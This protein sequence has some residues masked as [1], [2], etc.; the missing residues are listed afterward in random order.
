MIEQKPKLLILED[1]FDNQ[2]LL[3]YFLK[4]YLQVHVCSSAEQGY[5]LL[6]K[7]KFDVIVVDISIDGKRNGLEFT[8]ELKTN[9]NF[10]DIPILCLTAHAYTKDR[11]NA[12]EAGCDA[13]FSKPTDLKKL[14]NSLL[15]MS[16]AR[17]NYPI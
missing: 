15:A 11:I 7:E 8:K 2:K 17:K 16:A 9:P 4:K 1:D 14:L 6:H 3:K 13:Y 10:F 5:E 12:L